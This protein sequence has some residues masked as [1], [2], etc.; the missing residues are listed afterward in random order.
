MPKDSNLLPPHSQ[1]LLRAARSGRLYKRPP[2]LEEE[3]VDPDAIAPESKDKKED[4]NVVKGFSVK[5]WKQIP[6]NV[7]AP[8][9]SH[10]AKRRKGTITIASKTIEDRAPGPTVTRATVRRVDAAGNAYTEDVTLQEGHP[11][12]GEIISTRVE[13]A[14]GQGEGFAAPPPRRRPPPPKRKAKAGPG[15]GKKKIRPPLPMA[16]KSAGADRGQNGETVPKQ[17]GED[18]NVSRPANVL[19]EMGLTRCRASRRV[20][21]PLW[22]ARWLRGTT[23]TMRTTRTETRPMMETRAR[24]MKRPTSLSMT[25]PQSPRL[26]TKR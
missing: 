13:P 8:T 15:R 6:K 4:E 24:V 3:E 14:G 21:I 23:T 9:T 11:V 10:L 16:D 12:D 7:E 2:P 20:T 5:T 17:E 22:I 25:Q 1:E 26:K 19:A 18:D